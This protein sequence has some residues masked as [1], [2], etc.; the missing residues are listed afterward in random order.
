[1]QLLTRAIERALEQAARTPDKDPADTPIAMKLFT[2]DAQATWYVT[3]GE[4]LEDG[5]WRLFG[6]CDLGDPVCAELGYVML[7][8]LTNVRG[9]LGL[10]VERD[11]YLPP[12]TLAD[13]LKKYGKR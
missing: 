2:P 1:M 5:D 3:E 9:A 8:E 12:T 13:V 7:S 4:R 6:F 11:L 10:P